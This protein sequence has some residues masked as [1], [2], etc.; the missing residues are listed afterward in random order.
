MKEH[1]YVWNVFIEDVNTKDIVTYNI[2]D[3]CGFNKDCIEVLDKWFTHEIDNRDAFK[4][5]IRRLLLYYF[6]AKT[7]W[8][9]IISEVPPGLRKIEKKISVYDQMMLNFDIFID[10]I[11]NQYAY[12]ERRKNI[13]KKTENLVTCTKYSHEKTY[14]VKRS[15]KKPG[16]A[17]CPACGE[18]HRIKKEK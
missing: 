6:W 18:Y 7:E 5:I 8:Q 4:D 9:V 12:S 16:Y 17:I 2:F 1:N 15:R 3:H 11:C 14:L 13:M 10:V